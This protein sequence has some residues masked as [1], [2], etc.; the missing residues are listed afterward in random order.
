MRPGG[1]PQAYWDYLF[2]PIVSGGLM[3][4][5]SSADQF[6]SLFQRAV[7]DYHMA[8]TRDPGG[9]PDFGRFLAQRGFSLW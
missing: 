2:G 6:H 8:L 7:D 5:P 4:P 9:T 3:Y 1:G